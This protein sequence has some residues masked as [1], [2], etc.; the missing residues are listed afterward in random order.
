MPQ[1]KTQSFENHVRFVPAYHA[2]AFPIFVVNLGWAIY[3]VAVSFSVETV[4]GLLVAVALLIVFLYARMF[5]VTAQDRII[6]LEMRLR[7]ARLLPPE[8]QS[9]IDGFT[10]DQLVGMRFA[11]DE[12]LPELARKVVADNITD[13]T[14]IKKLVK[15]WQAD[16]LRV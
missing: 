4:I 10:V 5:A 6:R 14:A 11:S 8:L 2:V 12:E 15:H 7:L 16:W 1:Q 9:G 3:R 13:R